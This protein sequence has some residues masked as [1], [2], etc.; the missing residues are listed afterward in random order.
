MDHRDPAGSG[1]GRP[2]PAGHPE[3]GARGRDAT[4]ADARARRA[5]AGLGRDGRGR[6]LATLARRFG[7]LDLAEDMT[8]EAIAQA[9][10]TWPETGVPDSPEAW[11]KT[12]AKRKALDA[13]RRD[14]DLAQKLARL[15]VEEERAPVPAAFRDPALQDDAGPLVG[16]DRLEL[17]FACAHPALRLEDRVAL[18]LRFVAG[19]GTEEVAHALL[20]PVPTMQQRI[21]RAKRRIRALGIRFGAPGRDALAERFGGVLRV[22]YLLYAEGYARLAGER[23]VRDDLTAEAIRL[24]ALLRALAPRSAEARGLHALLLLTEARRAARTDDEGRPVPLARQDRG[25][26]DRALIA[27]GIGL[28]ESAAGAADAGPFAIQAAIAAV[29]AEAGSFDATDW[30]QIAVLYRLLEEREPGPVVR[31]GR[32]V[33][34]GRHR[35]A[36]EG[37]RRLDALG[38]DPALDRFRP[39]HIARA[40]TLE[41][42]G[43]ARAA[44]EAY[45][46]ALELPGNDAEDEFLAAAMAGIEREA[47]GA[48]GPGPAPAASP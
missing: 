37:L 43:E 34:I 22:V 29:H 18:T 25:R 2:G 41:E 7:D 17:C 30:A 40:I 36:E 48:G 20:V 33:A 44:R 28:A 23:H 15:R 12:V 5:L 11:L 31:L 10:R 1:A 38:G 9:L 47:R 35:G 26:W 45:R 46:R 24:A 8:Q 14:A 27:E 19:L 21:V 39:F 4:G 3:R 6:I 13:V 32:A 42:L 16:D